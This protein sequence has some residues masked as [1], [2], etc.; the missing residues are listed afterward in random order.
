MDNYNKKMK[1]TDTEQLL[2]GLP[3]FI[4]KGYGIIFFYLIIIQR[5]K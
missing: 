3:E 1:K 5:K 2:Q 4:N